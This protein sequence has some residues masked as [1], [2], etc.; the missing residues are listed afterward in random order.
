MNPPVI[1]E[2]LVDH[3]DGANPFTPFVVRGPDHTYRFARVS[4]A[5]AVYFP[6]ENCL[7]EDVYPEDPIP[8]SAERISV[9]VVD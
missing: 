4:V 2:S 8:N 1:V 3:L 7:C 9:V 6:N 5:T